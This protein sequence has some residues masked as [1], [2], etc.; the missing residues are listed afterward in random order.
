MVVKQIVVDATAMSVGKI[1][2]DS[3]NVIEKHY[4]REELLTCYDIVKDGEYRKV[5]V[6]SKGCS[7]EVQSV[8]TASED[9]Y[10]E[11]YI[12]TT[13]DE[14]GSFYA[15]FEQLISKLDVIFGE[16]P[17]AVLLA[18]LTGNLSGNVLESSLDG[19]VVDVV[20]INDSFVDSTL[21]IANFVLNNAPV[22]LTVSAVQYIASNRAR[23]TLAYSGNI[24]ENVDNLSL[25]VNSGELVR[26]VNLTSKNWTVIAVD[27]RTL[28]IVPASAMTEA[29]INGM[30]LTLE[31]TG[32]TFVDDGTMPGLTLNS[33]PVGLTI[34]SAVYATPTTVNVILAFDIA[35][36]FDLDFP[37]FSISLPAHRFTS[38][39]AK[40]TSP[41]TITAIVE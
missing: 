40:T 11:D 29:N 37:N 18:P 27:E 2:L 20:L 36:D 30:S 7:E 24:H 35:N 38:G 41:I 19:L 12:K 1:D 25:T 13:V 16:L 4:Y 17:N 3:A 14:K 28:T 5:V 9:P 6:K 8:L 26:A 23:I 34:D 10:S 32:D 31:L 22:G 33:Y 21:N 15:N 39:R